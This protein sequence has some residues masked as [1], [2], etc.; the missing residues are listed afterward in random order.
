MTTTITAVT[1]LDDQQRI[2]LHVTTT[3]TDVVAWRVTRYY[4]DRNEPVRGD[5]PD[6][7]FQFSASGAARTLYDTEAPRGTPVTYMVAAVPA[8]GNLDPSAR[9]APVVQDQSGDDCWWWAAPL[10]DPS[11]FV[12]FEPAIQPVATFPVENGVFRTL[13]RADPVVLFGTRGLPTGDLSARTETYA[14]ADALLAVV[15]RDEP[16]VIRA[17]PADGWGLY[18]RRYVAIDPIPVNRVGTGPTSRTGPWVLDLPWTELGATTV[19]VATFGA[20]YG[21]VVAAGL[22]Y[23]GVLDQ[24]GLYDALLAWVV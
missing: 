2:A 1:V 13:G 10:T 19:P 3:V 6:A 5:D 22:T 7:W 9:S 24:F 23:Q 16:I 18:G 14:Q 17:G 11:A 15:G 20:T 21:D 12:R 4:A 8:A